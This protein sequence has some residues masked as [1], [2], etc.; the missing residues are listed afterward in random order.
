MNENN[1]LLDSTTDSAVEWPDPLN[2]GWVMA[3]KQ[4]ADQLAEVVE[5]LLVHFGNEDQVRKARAV[6]EAHENF[7]FYDACHG[8]GAQ[9][10][11]G[12]SDG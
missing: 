6:L 7:T 12:P 5:G 10:D 2:V 9:S 3:W 11:G 8:T 4:M 1:A